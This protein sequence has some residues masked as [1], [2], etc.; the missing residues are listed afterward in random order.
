MSRET[1][2]RPALIMTGVFIAT[3]VLGVLVVSQDPVVG[4]TL[5]QLLRDQILG[6][7]PSGNPLLLFLAI[8]LNNLQA[9]VLLFLGGASLGAVTLFIAGTNGLVIGGVMEVVR[10]E[11]GILYVMAAIL[12]HGIVEIPSFILAGALGLALAEAL[13][14]EG[15]GVGDAAA[16]ARELGSVFLRAVLPLVALAAGIEAFITPQII[17]LVAQV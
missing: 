15:T 11:Q 8:F 1:L 4:K 3:L 2:V 12:P 16:V 5:V 6:S 13:W 7:I 9:C 10:Q 14:Q 17:S